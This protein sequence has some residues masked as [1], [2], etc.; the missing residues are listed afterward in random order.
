VLGRE[1]TARNGGNTIFAGAVW[2]PGGHAE[3]IKGG[4]FR[5]RPGATEWESVA[6]SLPERAEVQTITLYPNDPKTIFIG[7]HDGPYRSTDG[8]LYRSDDAAKSWKRI[9]HG[10]AAKSTIASL[11][12]HPTDPASL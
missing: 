7:T 9:D 3:H 4:L 12:A 1:V 6:G 11:A 8:S 5:L 2:G 10:V